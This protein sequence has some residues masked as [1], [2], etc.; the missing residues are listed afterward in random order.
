MV[1]RRLHVLIPTDFRLVSKI[2]AKNDISATI[3]R[4]KQFPK[5]LEGGHRMFIFDRDRTPFR[6][7]FPMIGSG[8]MHVNTGCFGERKELIEFS[9][10]ILLDLAWCPIKRAEADENP[11]AVYAQTLHARE[12]LASSFF[13]KL[14]PNLWR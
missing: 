12:V 9:Q 8:R 5:R 10:S 11:D 6:R 1:P 2:I 7:P 4:R 14:F 3:T 13:I